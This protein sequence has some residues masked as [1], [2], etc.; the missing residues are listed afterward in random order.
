MLYYLFA[1]LDIIKQFDLN[2]FQCIIL[3][4]FSSV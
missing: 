3:T 1:Y 4:T 2:E